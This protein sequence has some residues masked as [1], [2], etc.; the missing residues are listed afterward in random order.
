MIYSII[1][2]YITVMFREPFRNVCSRKSRV[3]GV[4][5]LLQKLSTKYKSWAASHVRSD[6][7]WNAFI[8]QANHKGLKQM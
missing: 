6:L 5:L 4:K 7:L 8:K 1:V 2:V 3:S